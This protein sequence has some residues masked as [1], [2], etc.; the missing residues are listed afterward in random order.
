MK[1]LREYSIAIIGATGNTGRKTLEILAERNFPISDIIVVASDKSINKKISYKNKVLKIV[2]FSSVD[3]S[4]VHIAFFCAGSSFSCKHAEYVADKGC[5]VIDKTSHFRLNPKVPL[6][7]P[8]VNLKAL[9]K[10]AAIGVISTPNCVAI[11]LTMTLKA[12][13]EIS[14]I[15]RAVVSTY[16]SVSGAGRNAVNEL[17]KQTK[18]SISSFNTTSEVFQKQIAFNIIPA[19]GN[20]M[21][22]GYS[23][24]EEKITSEV[25][26]ILK[27][28]IKLAITCVRVPVFIGHCMTVACEFSKLVTEEN[29]YEAFE[30]FDGIVTVD[31]RRSNEGFISPIDIQGEDAVYVSRI[32]KD[33]TVKNGIMYWVASD[34]L[35]KGAALNSVQIAEALISEDPQLTM[36]KKIK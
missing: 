31:R 1:Y 12:L 2:G 16:Q 13:S 21:P 22:S 25:C 3:F 10:G 6:I 11:P 26:K 28:D 7:I 32:R 35:R 20:I 34:N 29:V 30:N 14:A 24:E 5:V 8:E 19:I 9:N 15:K 4:K 18:D 33:N 27:S 23:E 17:F 36:F